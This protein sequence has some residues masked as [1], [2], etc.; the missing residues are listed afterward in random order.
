M[1]TA[2][3]S[4]FV[5]LAA[6]FPG[7]TACK[8]QCAHCEIYRNT[9]AARGE[10]AFGGRA[11]LGEATIRDRNYFRVLAEL[12]CENFGSPA[13]RSIVQMHRARGVFLW[14]T[15]TSGTYFELCVRSWRDWCRI[16]RASNGHSQLDLANS[17]P[18]REGFRG[19]SIGTPLLKSLWAF[20]IAYFCS[21]S[22]ANAY[23]LTQG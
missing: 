5:P 7:K 23:D 21:F 20:R 9:D 6:S 11:P 3:C 8:N 22:K 4:P 18:L 16:V 13:R 19:H 2:H 1:H 17:R 14:S 15:S 12:P 10:A